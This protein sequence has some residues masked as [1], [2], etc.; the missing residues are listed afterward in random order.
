V[1]FHIITGLNQKELNLKNNAFFAK[2]NFVDQRKI[3]NFVLKNV[4]MNTK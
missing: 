4:I 1:E 3:E 2:M